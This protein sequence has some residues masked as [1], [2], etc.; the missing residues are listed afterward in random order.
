[1]RHP[2]D[3]CIP[4]SILSVRLVLLYLF[5]FVC[6]GRKSFRF[7]SGTK[8]KTNKQKKK[9]SNV[10][11]LVIL[12]HTYWQN[13]NLWVY[14]TRGFVKYSYHFVKVFQSYQG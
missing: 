1:M 10:S 12:S 8:T 2:Y 4:V 3:Q 14:R 7:L 9:K 11:T 5:R 13:D 6:F